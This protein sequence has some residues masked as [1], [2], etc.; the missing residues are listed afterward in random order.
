[1]TFYGEIYYYYYYYYYYF[2]YYYYCYYYC[3]FKVMLICPQS[4]MK[5][6]IQNSTMV[7]HMDLIPSWNI[8]NQ[9]G[10]LMDLWLSCSYQENCEKV[11]Y[12]S[13]GVSLRLITTKLQLK[14]IRFVFLCWPHKIV[15]LVSALNKVTMWVSRP[16]WLALPPSIS[17]LGTDESSTLSPGLRSEH[18]RRHTIY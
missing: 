8:I 12:C 7:V 6:P 9:I 1:M 15:D 3:S 5:W 2:H 14:H 18:F 13:N 16:R 10:E 4:W 11:C 17:S